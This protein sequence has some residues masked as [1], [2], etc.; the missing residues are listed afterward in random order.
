MGLKLL[1][2]A[3]ADFSKAINL[4]RQS[5][6]AYFMRGAAYR[7]KQ[8]YQEALADFDRLIEI[9]P[10]IPGA[11]ND[12]SAGSRRGSSSEPEANSPSRYLVR[13][14]C[15]SC[16]SRSQEDRARFGTTSRTD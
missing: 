16:G 8:Q 5:S 11:Y 3:I 6:E 4:D 14:T 13:R 9:D 12:N 2:L 15:I 7:Q 10:R 1:D